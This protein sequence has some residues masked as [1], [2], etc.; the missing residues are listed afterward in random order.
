MKQVLIACDLF[1][2]SPFCLITCPCPY[3]IKAP[4]ITTVSDVLNPT[5]NIVT[6]VSSILQEGRGCSERCRAFSYFISNTTLQ[7]ISPGE[8]K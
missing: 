1:D 5:S 8:G 2:S 7:Q 6:F 4:S 3:S